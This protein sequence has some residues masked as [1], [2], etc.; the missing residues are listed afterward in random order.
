M[1]RDSLSHM[2]QPCMAERSQRLK[3]FCRSTWTVTTSGLRK[4][5][6]SAWPGIS[7]P[8][9]MPTPPDEGPADLRRSAQ[10]TVRICWQLSG[11]PPRWRWGERHHVASQVP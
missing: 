8:P 3:V 9:G 11:T 10:L 4:S 5:G 7:A 6:L 2:T 1:F